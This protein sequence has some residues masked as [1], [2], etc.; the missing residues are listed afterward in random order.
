M[1]MEAVD[2]PILTPIPLLFMFTTYLPA[3]SKML[4]G[5]LKVIIDVSELESV[6]Q[7]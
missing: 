1:E 4:I 2:N 6:V 3:K 5:E 7:V